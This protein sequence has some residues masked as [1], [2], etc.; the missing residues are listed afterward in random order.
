MNNS[1][2]DMYMVFD[3]ISLINSSNFYKEYS[4]NNNSKKSYYLSKFIFDTMNYMNSVTEEKYKILDFIIVAICENNN[5]KENIIEFY[6]SLEK[7][8]YG[9]DNYKDIDLYIPDKFIQNKLNKI[10]YT[11]L[12]PTRQIYD[13]FMD[14]YPNSLFV[15]KKYKINSFNFELWNNIEI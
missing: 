10:K 3:I 2:Y 1:T 4:K 7:R 14:V 8:G 12:L 11:M 13:I 9:I 5:P 6:N 15:S